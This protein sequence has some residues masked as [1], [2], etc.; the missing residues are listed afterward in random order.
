[1]SAH[2][3]HHDHGHDHDHGAHAPSLPSAHGCCSTKRDTTEATKAIV[4]DPVCGMQVDPA[5]SAHRAE[6]AGR[7]YHFCSA[8]CVA[9]SLAADPQAYLEPKPAASAEPAVPLLGTA[10]PRPRTL[11]A[12]ST[13]SAA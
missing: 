12:R 3:K 2:G 4:L 13:R 9:R 5:T 8:R 6:H 7:Y 11:R 10:P 1:M